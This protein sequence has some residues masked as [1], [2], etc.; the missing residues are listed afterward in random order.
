M[1]GYLRPIFLGV[2]DD[3][4]FTRAR[5]VCNIPM[6]MSHV[7]SA[8]L[9]RT[10]YICQ[11]FIET[12]EEDDRL[13][14]QAAVDRTN[15]F[16][17]GED[18][19]LV[20]SVLGDFRRL[21]ATVS[22]YP[23]LELSASQITLEVRF[24]VPQNVDLRT[25]YLMNGVLAAATAGQVAQTCVDCSGPPD[26]VG[27]NVLAFD[28]VVDKATAEPA[29]DILADILNQNLMSNIYKIN[30]TAFN[31]SLIITEN[32]AYE[33]LAEVTDGTTHDYWNGSLL[34]GGV[35]DPGLLLTPGTSWVLT[36]DGPRYLSRLVIY[37]QPDANTT[38]GNFKISITATS[39]V[40]GSVSVGP[41][42]GQTVYAHYFTSNRPLA[43]QITLQ[44]YSL[45]GGVG[46]TI[47]NVE[48]FSD[49]Q[50]CKSVPCIS[51]AI[52]S[53]D[54]PECIC[55]GDDLRYKTGT[56]CVL[57]AP[58]IQSVSSPP[59]TG[60]IVTII[61]AG[62]QSVTS[63]MLGTQVLDI[64]H[65]FEDSTCWF[66]APAGN[67]GPTQQLRVERYP[68]K[69]VSPPLDLFSYAPPALTRVQT[70]PANGSFVEL[71]GNNLGTDFSKLAPYTLMLGTQACRNPTI[72]TPHLCFRCDSTGIT[73]TVSA[74]LSLTAFQG[75]AAVTTILPNIVLP[76][77]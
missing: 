73:G 8:T 62:L 75:R 39:G 13:A 44:Y 32:I 3:D 5:P 56:G 7:C 14:C 35:A 70:I 66:W 15:F 33:R 55:P 18:P 74:N 31:D 20:D 43:T 38:F 72:I 53:T 65:C 37:S 67:Y 64:R 26:A 16:C 51:P 21:L 68:D 76:S 54:F 19:F 2:H 28:I 36:L 50:S 46:P 27:F 61:G 71:C 58:Q 40:T 23:V 77:G 60:G 48:A 1:G 22:N 12:Y 9:M 30:V 4:I 41:L 11:E 29:F 59:T 25:K 63:V 6:G 57:V 49:V 52:C 42:V 45:T 24:Q 10:Q 47:S 69:L 17:E 34:V